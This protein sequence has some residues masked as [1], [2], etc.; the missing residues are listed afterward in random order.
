MSNPLR[1]VANNATRSMSSLLGLMPGWFQGA[2]HD[3]YKDFGFPQT[4]DF[5][6]I[7]GT[8]ARNGIAQAAITKTISKTWQENP[9]LLE[10][11]RDGSQRGKANETSLEKEIRL[12]FDELRLWQK[13]AE[14]D[15]RGM[16]GRYGAVIVRYA[17]GLKFNQPVGRVPGGLEG[18]VELIPVWEGQ[19][20][21][22]TWDQDEA[23]EAYGW[24]TMFSY[25][26]ADVVTGKANNR[27][28]EVHPDRVLVWSKDGTVN[29]ES[30]LKA[31]YN[32]LLTI[33]KII[34]AGGEGFWKNAK[35]APVFEIDK[36]ANLANMMK[37]MGATTGEELANKM[38]EQVESYS[39]GFDQ[40]LLLMGMQ[41]KQLNVT[42]PSPEH[43]FSTALQSFA[44]SM[45]IPLK[46]LVGNQTGERA[47]SEDNED[48]AQ[49]NMARR[50]NIVV[51]NIMLL[52]KRWIDYGILPPGNDYFLDWTDL[53]EAS[54]SERIDR[55]DKMADINQKMKDTGEIVFTSE[56]IRK[57]PGY[58][59]LSEAEKYRDDTS[60][61]DEAAALGGPAADA[62]DPTIDPEA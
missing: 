45:N 28:I 20:K 49:T 26:E 29:G 55:A 47:S 18:V 24:P 9:F 25:N 53:T 2:K 48:W 11:E 16:V 17:D 32:D 38:D 34:G 58:E 4:L 57:V 3:I 40:M 19:L 12:R 54:M 15:R 37:A 10:K 8:Y 23:S 1:L 27:A 31:G 6:T 62:L 42:L 52:V 60:A 50:A 46:V 56:E 21:V 39:K 59:P 5:G 61:E 33:E 43:F 7:H 30:A 41:A 36:E 22:A 14:A 51:P 35:S 13:L 44:A